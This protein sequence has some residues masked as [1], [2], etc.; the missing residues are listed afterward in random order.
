MLCPLLYWRTDIHHS[1]LTW[2]LFASLLALTTV[3]K[4]CQKV[5]LP[6][7]FFCSHFCSRGT[8]G[9]NKWDGICNLWGGLLPL[10]DLLNSS[11][12]HTSFPGPS[13]PVF[14]YVTFYSHWH[15]LL[16]VFGCLSLCSFVTH[17]S[18]CNSNKSA[19]GAQQI[20]RICLMWSIW[21]VS[22]QFTW[23]KPSLELMKKRMQCHL[24]IGKFPIKLKMLLQTCISSYYPFETT[25]AITWFLCVFSNK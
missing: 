4:A 18:S 11:F 10:S 5:V 3:W 14:L 22:D 15:Q 23:G 20:A 2:P 9:S 19:Q 8:W 17:L 1:D 7:W 25:N 6:H 13:S 24:F 12:L 16:S 21:G